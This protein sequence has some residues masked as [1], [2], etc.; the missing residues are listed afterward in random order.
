[1]SLHIYVMYFHK[2][3]DIAILKMWRMAI[4]CFGQAFY[5]PKNLE[6]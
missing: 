2:Y 1:M 3:R 4:L 6:L 5:F